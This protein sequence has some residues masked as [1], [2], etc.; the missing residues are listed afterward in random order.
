MKKIF[1][2]LFLS[3]YTT[4]SIGLNI[5]VHTCGGE[6]DARL[7]TTEAKDPCVCGDEMPMAGMCCTTVLKTV[8]LDD[9]QNISISVIEE[10]LVAVHEVFVVTIIPLEELYSSFVISSDTS[11]PPNKDF[12]ESNSVFLI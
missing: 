9:S 4:L 7:V 12:Q 11:P 3:V 8:M 2:I 5:L 6:S 1:T 10:K